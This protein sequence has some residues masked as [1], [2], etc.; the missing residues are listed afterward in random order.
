MLWARSSRHRSS[1]DRSRGGPGSGGGVT[2]DQSP[3]KRWL[4]ARVVWYRIP[5][6]WDCGRTAEKRPGVVDWGSMSSIFSLGRALEWS[7]HSHARTPAVWVSE[8][9]VTRM[10][11]WSEKNATRRVSGWIAQ[12]FLS[13]KGKLDRILDES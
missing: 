11:K 7:R 4:S 1:V 10:T 6:P 12:A 2:V 8:K 9:N 5:T 3:K 13:C